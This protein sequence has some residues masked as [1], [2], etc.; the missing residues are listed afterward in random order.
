[1][2]HTSRVPDA[3]SNPLH[4]AGDESAVARPGRFSNIP[5]EVEWLANIVNT[6]T[7]QAYRGDIRDFVGFTGIQKPGEFAC[8]ARADV[9]AWRSEL[10]RRGLSQATIRRKLAALS[11]LFTHLC[12][13]RAAETNPTLGVQ[14]PKTGAQEGKTPA[15]S[16]AQARALL[17]AP[18]S[19][20]LQGKRDRAI[21]STLLYHGLRKDELCRLRVRDLQQ[22]GGV[23]HFRVEGKGSKIR[24]IPAH[25]KTLSQI[26]AYLAEAGHGANLDGALF[27]PL[28]NPVSGILEKALSGTTVYRLI[29]KRYA[30]QVGIP[31]AG[32]CVHSL[33]ATAATNALEHA[34]DM[35][36]VQD[37]LGHAFIS[38]TRLYDRRRNRPEDS[39]TFKIEY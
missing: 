22:R 17:D 32:C 26:E 28:K 39:P 33:R 23:P 7:R 5:L 14:R 19:A 35:A 27:R 31:A 38:T 25:P 2:K 12:E 37:W 15:I 13:A 21:L 29:V 24:Y 1:M 11:S 6:R 10:E 3:P 4:Q 8:I 36:K 30:K 9:L 20:T 18:S 34:A 16:D